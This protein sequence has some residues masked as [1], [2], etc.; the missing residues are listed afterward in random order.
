MAGLGQLNGTHNGVLSF[1]L[2]S[3]GHAYNPIRVA[4]KQ[5]QDGKSF[6]VKTDQQKTELILTAGNYTCVPILVYRKCCLQ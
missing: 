6:V 3:G 4:C 1:Q 2:K 5:A